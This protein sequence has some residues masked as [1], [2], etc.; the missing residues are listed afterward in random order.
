M[1]SCLNPCRKSYC[2]TLPILL[3]LG[4]AAKAWNAKSMSGVYPGSVHCAMLPTLLAC[5]LSGSPAVSQTTQKIYSKIYAA[6]GWSQDKGVLRSP[7][8]GVNETATI[9]RRF[10]FSSSLKRMSCIVKAC[11]PTPT[12]SLAKVQSV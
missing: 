5:V 9:L 7:K 10:H 12:Y 3:C 11:S 4:S 8:N 6:A 2:S 1:C